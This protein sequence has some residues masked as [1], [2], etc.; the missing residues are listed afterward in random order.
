MYKASHDATF[1]IVHGIKDVPYGSIP[2]VYFVPY[3][4]GKATYVYR[5]EWS[6]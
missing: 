2:H 4:Y 6:V 3:A 1:L 5:C